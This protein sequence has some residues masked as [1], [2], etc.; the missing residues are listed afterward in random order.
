MKA[1]R[2]KWVLRGGVLALAVAAGLLA[3]LAERGSEVG[4]GSAETPDVQIV[5][6]AALAEAA[7]LG[8]HP[9]YWAGRIPGT[10]LGLSEGADGTVL[11]R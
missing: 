1:A 5:R 2:G 8:G 10:E 3:W 9:V 11:V 4:S 6:P 7:A